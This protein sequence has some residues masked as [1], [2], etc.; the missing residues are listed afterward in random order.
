[1]HALTSSVKAFFLR[2]I[3]SQASMSSTGQPYKMPPQLNRQIAKELKNADFRVTIF[4]SARIKKGTRVWKEVY[5]IAKAVGELHADVV[6]GGGPGLMEAASLGHRAS[7]NHGDTI[8]L[9]I[10]LP[11][12]QFANKHLNIKQDFDTFSSRLDTFILL[13]N[14]VVVAPGGVGTCLEFF[15]VWQLMQV[16]H[17]CKIPIIMLGPMW[18]GLLKW[19]ERSPV[20][21]G[22]I[23]RSDLDSII[24][25]ETADQAIKVLRHAHKMFQKMG[26]EACINLKMYGQ[27][28]KIIK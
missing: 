5:K 25:V 22:L 11:K 16:H 7:R 19:V 10:T 9:N 14:V 1:M 28:L 18:K 3:Q 20:K 27:R 17:I 24:V 26:N 4:G 23:S 6:T 12:E 2:Y 13:S 21:D 8:G 15:Y